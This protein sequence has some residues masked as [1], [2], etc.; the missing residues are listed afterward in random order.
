MDANN[1][2][3]IP[4]ISDSLVP[5]RSNLPPSDN[6]V[7]SLIED[8]LEFEGSKSRKKMYKLK[9]KMKVLAERYSI[10]EKRC[11]TL[12]KELAA[13]NE[14]MLKIVRALIAANK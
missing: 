9:R 8:E 6:E 2:S 14:I 1:N 12:E 3:S 13:Q 4:R 11:E 10:L 5:T 7:P